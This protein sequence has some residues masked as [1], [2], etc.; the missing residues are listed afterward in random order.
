MRILFLV[1]L[2][3]LAP[4]VAEEPDLGRFFKGADATF[5]LRGP[6]RD[7]RWNPKRAAVGYIPASTFKI[8]NTVIALD[9]GVVDGADFYLPWDGAR[10]P[11]EDFWPDT[12]A[13]AQ[14][15]KSAFRE[16]V[17]CFY[18]ELARRIGPERMQAIPCQVQHGAH[19]APIPGKA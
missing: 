16:T 6:D 3:T 10:D 18:Q 12:W 14:T 4:A 11:R 9:T 5:V 13:G 1:L 7:V 17:V 15:L 8:P 2:L 19:P